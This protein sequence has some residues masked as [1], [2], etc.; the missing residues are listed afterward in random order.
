MPFAVW[1]IL[2]AA[3]LPLLAVVPAKINRKYDN[4]R[5]RNPEFW[6]EGFA[7]RAMGAQ[8]NSLESFPFFAIAVLVALGYGGDPSWVDSLCGLYLSIRAVYIFVYWT[9]RPGLR[10]LAWFVGWG[11][12]IAIFTSP[13]WS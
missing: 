10:S 8:L 6:K 2:V 9:N 12:T 3:I 11:A 5:P 4:A 1:S 7:E 13:A